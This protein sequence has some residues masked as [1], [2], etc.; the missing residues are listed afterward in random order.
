M[1]EGV[2]LLQRGDSAY[3]TLG[4]LLRVNVL[5]HWLSRVLQG[6]AGAAAAAAALQ[7]TS[8]AAAARSGRQQVQQEALLVEEGLEE[9]QAAL[10]D[11]LAHC[12]E[13]LSPWQVNNLLTKAGAGIHQQALNHKL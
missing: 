9:L 13:P 11:V 2:S 1:F 7:P 3:I 12:N 6:D 8:A 10:A 5:R 4:D